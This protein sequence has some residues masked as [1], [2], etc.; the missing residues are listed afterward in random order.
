M[1][2]GIALPP[3]VLENAV[4]GVLLLQDANAHVLGVFVVGLEEP[5]VDL[6]AFRRAGAQ[7]VRARGVGMRLQI[8]N[9]PHLQGMHAGEIAAVV[10][11][12]QLRRVFLVELGDVILVEQNL[13]FVAG[14]ASRA[15]IIQKGLIVSEVPPQNLHSAMEIDEIAGIQL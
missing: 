6:L 13:E 14:L 5:G 2:K 1:A 9:E 4:E 7:G 8:G 15:L 11:R 12:E 10:E 3:P